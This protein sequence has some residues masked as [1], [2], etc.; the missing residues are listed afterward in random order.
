[1]AEN[2]SPCERYGAA[3]GQR[4][5][6]HSGVKITQEVQGNE[7]FAIIPQEK[8]IQQLQEDC[9]FYVWDE[10]ASEVRWVCSFDTTESDIIEFINLLRKELC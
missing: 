4:S 1:M 9:F 5:G 8:K 7:I 6:N 2:R 10:N 3:F